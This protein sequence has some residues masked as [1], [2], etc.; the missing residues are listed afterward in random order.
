MTKA[1]ESITALSFAAAVTCSL[2]AS[3]VSQLGL[4]F[5]GLGLIISSIFFAVLSVFSWAEWLPINKKSEK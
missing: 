5:I 1:P 3:I 4:L 2:V